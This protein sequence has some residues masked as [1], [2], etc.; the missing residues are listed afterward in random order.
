MGLAVLVQMIP[1][2]LLRLPECSCR[3]DA[4][5]L[6]RTPEFVEAHHERLV[7]DQIRAIGKDQGLLAQVLDAA[8][9]QAPDVDEADLR[10]ALALFDPVWDAL[11]AKEQARVL[12]LLIE[13]VAYDREAGTVEVA[14]RPTGIQT[15]AEEVEP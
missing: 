2:Q 5:A 6:L 11:H 4:L 1:H 14:F 7:V 3:A 15:L 9:E 13:R 10:R 8:R 12:T